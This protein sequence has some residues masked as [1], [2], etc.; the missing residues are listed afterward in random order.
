MSVWLALGARIRS[1]RTGSA[2]LPSEEE[3]QQDEQD[4]EGGLNSASSGSVVVQVFHSLWLWQ[5]PHVERC[6]ES[7]E[8]GGLLLQPGTWYYQTGV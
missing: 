8:P 3:N 1:R 6:D 4:A 2:T 5:P 7:S